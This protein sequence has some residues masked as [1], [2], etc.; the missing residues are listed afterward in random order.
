M[1]GRFLELNSK[2]NNQFDW[3]NGYFMLKEKNNFGYEDEDFNDGHKDKCFRSP[4]YSKKR[5]AVDYA[6]TNKK[7]KVYKRS[8]DKD[9]LDRV[10]KRLI[11]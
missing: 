10:A 7:T 3:E 1:S 8:I 11:F 5:K 9:V 2:E 4:K 6:G